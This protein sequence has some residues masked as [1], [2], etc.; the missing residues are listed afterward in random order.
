MTTDTKTYTI[1]EAKKALPLVKRIADDLE[2]AFAQL[3]QIPHGIS[4]LYQA[5]DLDEIPRENQTKI[6]LLMDQIDALESELAELEVEL[7]GFDPVLIDFH[8]LLEGKEIYLCWAHGETDI[9]FYHSLDGGFKAR[10]KL[11]D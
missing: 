5:V 7:K 11:T 4:F 10:K 2:E 3:K 9:E 1:Q 6:E 8:S